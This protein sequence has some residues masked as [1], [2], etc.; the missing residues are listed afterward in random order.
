MSAIP[1]AQEAE[2]RRIAVR[3]QPRQIVHKTLSWKKSPSQKLAGGV[4]Q[5]VGSEFKPQYCKKTKTDKKHIM[6]K[7]QKHYVK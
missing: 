1:A 5:G 6:D 4:A 7:S 3:S 2:I